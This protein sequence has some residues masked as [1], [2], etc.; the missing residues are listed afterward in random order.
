MALFESYERRIDQINAVLNSYG[1]SSIEEAEKITKDAGLDVYD[2][3]KKIQPICF[4]NACWAY[5]VGAAI[6][7][8]KGC[9]RAA[10]AAAAIGEG[11]QAFCI[12][13]SVADHRKVGLGH[14]NLGKMLLEE[15]TECF[16]FLAGHESFAAAEGAIGIAEKANKVRKKPL[17]VILNGLGKDAAQIISRI[18]GFTFVETQYDYKAAKLNVVYEKAYSN[19]LRATVK[20]YGA[21]DVQEGVAIMHHENVGVSI[22]GN[23]T[24]PTRF[25]HPVAGTYKKECIEQGKKYFSVASGG[26]YSWIFMTVAQSTLKFAFPAVIMIAGIKYLSPTG[27]PT[28]K[29]LYSY[30]ILRLAVILVFWSGLY[31]FIEKLLIKDK[32][33][34]GI[35][36]YLAD[37][38]TGQN[39]LWLIYGLMGLLIVS[40]LLKKIVSDKKILEYFLIIWIVFTVIGNII[41]S[42]PDPYINLE[43]RIKTFEM[44]AAIHFSISA[45][46]AV[47]S[48]SGKTIILKTNLI[49]STCLSFA[50]IIKVSSITL[51]G[52]QPLC[53]PAALQLR[54]KI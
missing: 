45:R 44:S 13:G 39:H 33:S 7:I 27:A 29:R 17:R 3:V 5:T 49:S 18:N 35:K 15:E 11:L 52:C 54:G 21:D 32:Y 50:T 20:C 43:K 19:G 31:I 1:I 16:C 36:Q 26:S 38:T 30:D 25:Q 23:S 34:F 14:G 10:D 48:Q 2:Q 22:T 28:L 37:L 46:K 41:V 40:P 51:Q 12:P 4:E 6:A 24:N 9:R 47:S 8:K 42:I 53:S